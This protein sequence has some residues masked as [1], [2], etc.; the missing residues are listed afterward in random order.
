MSNIIN[1]LWGALFFLSFSAIAQAQQVLSVAVLTTNERQSDIYRGVFNDF[2]TQ[3]SQYDVNVTFFSDKEFKRLLPKWLETGEFDL[4]Y[5]QAGERLR[6]LI[7]QDVIQPIDSLLPR[8]ELQ[9]AI[10]PAV[11]RSVTHQS[12]SNADAATYALPIAHYGWGFYYN[13]AVFQELSVKPPKNWKEFIALCQRIKA[14]GA[15]PLVQAVQ[16]SWPVLAWLDYLSLDAGGLEFRQ[17]LIDGQ[18][19]SGATADIFLKQF[20]Q[21]LSNEWF[22]APQRHW[23]WQQVMKVVEDKQAAMTLMGQ[24]AEGTI[25]PLL[26]KDIGFFS[27]P[28]ANQMNQAEVAPLEIW[29]VPR[30][31]K[32]KAHLAPLLR[33]LLANNKE[34]AMGFDSLPV[35][36]TQFTQDLPS[37]RVKIAA[38]SLANSSTL[39][40]F[41]DR[42]AK[43]DIAKNAARSIAKSIHEDNSASL[44]EGI[45]KRTHIN[46]ETNTFAQAAELPQLYFASVTGVKESFFASNLMQE[47]YQQ[48]GYG[49]SVTRF[50]SLEASLNAY[51]FGG[52]GE[53]MRVDGYKHLA[54]SLQQIPEPLTNVSF[55]LVCKDLDMCATSLPKASEVSVINDLLVV[56]NWANENQVKL[57]KYDTVETLFRA[58]NDNKQGLMVLGASEII[59]NKLLISSSTYRTII[60]VPLYHYVH[61]KHKELIP[62]IDS[63]L[64][65]YKKTEQYQAL[66]NRYWLQHN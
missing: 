46:Y 51:R 49:I 2:S 22:F 1:I 26:N 37:D 25:D 23:T 13:K 63:A 12:A 44:R 17:Q 41:F 6:S 4:L 15:N 40:Q 27:F 31:A 21:L 42:E 38:N 19:L 47:I 35:V 60:T 10:Q 48:L 62:L 57:K 8:E 16:E 9:S 28:K 52:D 50:G 34:M 64:K 24:F 56:N 45:L 39:V 32:N 43:D 18:T 53:L 59:D 36:N 55:Y 66:K 7:A 3:S 5:W 58:F 29:V 65:E 11:L 20:E 61:N 54:P 33:F 30:S 14:Q